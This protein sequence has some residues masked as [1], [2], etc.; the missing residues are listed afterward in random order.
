ML[1]ATARTGSQHWVVKAR[2]YRTAAA[3]KSSSSNGESV[4]SCANKQRGRWRYGFKP[5]LANPAGTREARAGGSCVLRLSVLA[6][7][8]RRRLTKGAGG[9]GGGNRISPWP[10]PTAK[11]SS[12]RSWTSM[13]PEEGMRGV[14]KVESA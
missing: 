4:G 10:V 3:P 11:A 6:L 9:S 1:G 8:Q 13:E 12:S 5:G 14:L 2:R 7:Q